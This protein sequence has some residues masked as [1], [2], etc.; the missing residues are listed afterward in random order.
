MKPQCANSVYL[1]APLHKPFGLECKIPF[2]T[3]D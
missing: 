1:L 3:D 2:E